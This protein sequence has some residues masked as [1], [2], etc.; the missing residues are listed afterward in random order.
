MNYILETQYSS[1]IS[2][3]VLVLQEK[4]VLSTLTRKWWKEKYSRN[5][6]VGFA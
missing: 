6:Q 2:N 5:C 4:G 1:T 3:G